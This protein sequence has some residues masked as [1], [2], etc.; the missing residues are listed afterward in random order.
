MLMQLNADVGTAVLRTQTS[1]VAIQVEG[2]EL[3]LAQIRRHVLGGDEDLASVA[4]R[5]QVLDLRVRL[6]PR[7]ARAPPLDPGD[8]AEDL[9]G[10]LSALAV[11]PRPPRSQP[12]RRPCGAPRAGCPCR[13]EVRRSQALTGVLQRWR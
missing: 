6:D 13:P 7:V 9:R 3:A 2:D 4:A 11:D 12:E 10:H 1:L 8:G 5:L